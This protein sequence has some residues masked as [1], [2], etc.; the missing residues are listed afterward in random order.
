[1]PR[2][3]F[4]SLRVLSASR[5]VASQ[6]ILRPLDVPATSTTLRSWTSF[7]PRKFQQFGTI[8]GMTTVEGHDVD[9]ATDSAPQT[10]TAG[11]DYT[12]SSHQD[13]ISRITSLERQLQDSTKRLAQLTA[14]N[15]APITSS[16]SNS[17]ARSR[18]SSP[19]RLRPFDPSLYSTRHIALKFAYLG[20]RYNGFEHSNGNVVPRPTIEEALW[21]ALRK[22]RLI[23]PPTE[24]GSD[25]VPVDQSYEVLWEPEKR[26]GQYTDGREMEESRGQKVKLEINWDDCQY[27]KCGRTDRGVSAFG[28]VIGIRV[29]SNQPV[30]KAPIQDT[31]GDDGPGVQ[32]QLP[33]SQEDSLTSILDDEMPSIDADELDVDNHTKPF[34]P[35]ADEL[36]Y[37]TILNSILPPDIRILAWCPAPPPAFDARFSCGERRYKYFFTNPAF[38]PTPGP[39]GLNMYN[40]RP[41]KVR[42]GWLD[43]EKM[44]EAAKKLEGLH[45][46][47]NLCK[48]DP[49]KQM[50]N[51]QRRVTFADVVEFDSPGKDFSG[52]QELNQTGSNSLLQSVLKS[53]SGDLVSESGP[54]VYTICIHGTAFLWHQVRCMA[55]IL[56]LV[57]QGLEEPSIV[58]ELL[59]VDKNPRRPLYEMADD[60]PLVLWDCIFP[61]KNED[62]RDG[63]DWVYGGDERS[64]TALTSKGDGRFGSAGVIDELWRQW[65]EAKMNEVLAGS[66]LDL[67][68]G[69]GDGSSFT[70]GGQRGELPKN[71]TRSAKVFDG[72]DGARTVGKYVPV[73]RKPKLDSLEEQNEKWAKTRGWKRELKKGIVKEKEEDH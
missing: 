23:S 4:F 33:P 61:E 43:I 39:Y 69:Q 29:R 63:L 58:D 19:R 34:D 40:G 18:S 25:G 52:I 48:I 26:L 28:Q 42:E 2:I 20:Q 38:C 32:C 54:K 50:P 66:L 59:D 70:R 37:I 10:T 56:F 7:S 41:A 22:A 36:S 12:S 14:Q 13:L 6:T 31:N 17:P 11:D 73:M 51:C 47:R 62:M 21:K 67:A 44:R 72:G 15:G 8:A 24:P 16:A 49:T 65:R 46:F 60:A 53:V 71:H 57:G 30:E 9:H 68:L 35:I 64:L 27:S 55:A 45:D 3:E 1:M 5:L